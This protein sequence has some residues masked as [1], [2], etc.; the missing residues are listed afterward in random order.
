LVASSAGAQ[1]W[2]D[3]GWRYGSMPLTGPRRNPLQVFDRF[4]AKMTSQW[5]SRVTPSLN[6]YADVFARHRKC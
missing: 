5:S 4:G 1:V 6:N 2:Q 3:C